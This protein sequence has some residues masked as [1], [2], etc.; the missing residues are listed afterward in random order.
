VLS[1][2]FSLLE[3]VII[4]LTLQREDTQPLESSFPR[5]KKLLDE[6]LDAVMAYF[7]EPLP[8]SDAAVS[9]AALRLLGVW[10]AEESEPH[11]LLKDALPSILK[12]LPTLHAG[13][14]FVSHCSYCSA[15]SG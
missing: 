10:L 11:S 9:L 13:D 14:R 3:N 4:S 6:A 2:C 1:V 5:L 8:P 15:S 12:L 7:S